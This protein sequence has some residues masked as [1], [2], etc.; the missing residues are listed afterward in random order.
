MLHVIHFILFSSTLLSFCAV[1]CCVNKCWW[2]EWSFFKHHAWPNESRVGKS[3]IQE[4][5]GFLVFS[6]KFSFLLL[7][8]FWVLFFNKR[9]I[10][11]IYLVAWAQRWSK[12]QGLGTSALYVDSESCFPRDTHMWTALFSSLIDHSSMVCCCFFFPVCGPSG[13]SLINT[14]TFSQNIEKGSGRQKR[15][16]PV[17]MLIHRPWHVLLFE[18][19]VRHK[20]TT[21]TH[22]HT[23]GPAQTPVGLIIWQQG[24]HCAVLWLCSAAPSPPGGKKHLQIKGFLPLPVKTRISQADHVRVRGIQI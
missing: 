13:K 17:R 3:L 8:A 24:A 6:N 4:F 18:T 10:L 22:T 5:Q 15:S 23:H 11:F 16:L 12:D 19:A 7:E 20:Q 14:L 9:K 2:I 1:K 21:G